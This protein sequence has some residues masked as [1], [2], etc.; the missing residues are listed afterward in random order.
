MEADLMG[1]QRRLSNEVTGTEHMQETGELEEEDN[2]H[3]PW[4]WICSKDLGNGRD[5]SVVGAEE[6][7]EYNGEVRSWVR[8]WGWVGHCGFHSEGVAKLLGGFE[9]GNKRVIGYRELKKS[10]KMP[11]RWRGWV[12]WCL[13]NLHKQNPREGKP[14]GN[15]CR[16]RCGVVAHLNRANMEEGRRG[17]G[18]T[19]RNELAYSLYPKA[20]SILVQSGNPGLVTLDHVWLWHW[21]ATWSWASHLTSLRLR[22]S[23]VICTMDILEQERQQVGWSYDTLGIAWCTKSWRGLLMGKSC[24]FLFTYLTYALS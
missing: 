16:K 5:A 20:M 4:V 11:W 18:D 19:F 10:G 23:A 22:I 17:E 13:E 12:E 6:G 24:P 15:N 7:T 14:G 1:W 8:P 3:R 21:P 2:G 9:R